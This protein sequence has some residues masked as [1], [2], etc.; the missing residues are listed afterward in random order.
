MVCLSI[1]KALKLLYFEVTVL[2]TSSKTAV[3]PNNTKHCSQK[4]FWCISPRDSTFPRLLVTPLA[5]ASHQHQFPPCAKQHRCC[6]GVRWRS[7]QRIS[8]LFRILKGTF[9]PLSMR[10]NAA[11]NRLIVEGGYLSPSP[12][13]VS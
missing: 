8:D 2:L 13:R 5:H 3:H 9:V 4:T 7:Q 1:G 12:L 11:K 10:W 6:Q